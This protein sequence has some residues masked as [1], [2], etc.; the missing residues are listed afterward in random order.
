MQYRTRF[1]D[2][3]AVLR[4]ISTSGC[5]LSSVSVPVV[6]REKVLVMLTLPEEK[7]KI[8]ATGI[9]TRVDADTFAVAFT[10][11]ESATVKL[12]QTFFFKT[13]RNKKR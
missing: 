7:E 3:E 9:V 8:E 1:D 6:L 2:G 11:I 10:L 12:I 13:L 4:D 5:A